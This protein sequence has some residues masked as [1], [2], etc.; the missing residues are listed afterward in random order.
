MK[1]RVLVRRAHLLSRITSGVQ[2]G[3]GPCHRRRLVEHV[4][5][6]HGL[7]KVHP[8]SC[9]WQRIL[10]PATSNGTHRADPAT[11]IRA[12]HQ[13]IHL[14][15]STNQHHLLLKHTANDLLLTS[16]HRATKQKHMTASDHRDEPRRLLFINM[17]STSMTRQEAHFPVLA[18][19][20]AT[21][22]G[23][24]IK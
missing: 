13:A 22:L 6:M 2:T 24:A 12:A 8:C 15:F 4:I 18:K 20:K 19:E 16:L 23:S 21:N 1:L 17:N 14:A 7:R 11:W 3:H 10:P 5:V 9:S